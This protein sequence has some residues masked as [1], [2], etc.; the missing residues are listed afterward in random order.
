VTEIF[1]FTQSQ[2]TELLRMLQAYK[3]GQLGGGNLVTPQGNLRP[4]IVPFKF[5]ESG[6]TLVPYGIAEVY[7]VVTA[8][9]PRLHVRR[10]TGDDAAWYIINTNASVSH[11]ANGWGTLAT[12]APALALYDDAQTPAFGKEWGPQPSSYGL[13][14]GRTGFICQGTG[15]GGST[16]RVSVIQQGKQGIYFGTNSASLVAKG[17]NAIVTMKD[18]SG[19]TFS[20]T[21]SV[22][23]RLASLEASYDCHIS[24]I[25]GVWELV[26]KECEA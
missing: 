1:G 22:K 3:A 18:A 16:D 24:M 20:F 2:S 21:R 11:N 7:G 14:R 17:S 23:C 25:D 9:E 26:G 13:K 15:T 10:P 4:D 6:E 8:G 5:V 12:C 19:T